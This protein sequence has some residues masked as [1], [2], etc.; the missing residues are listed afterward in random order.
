MKKKDCLFLCQFFSPEYV[1]SATLPFDTAVK[2]AQEGYEIGALCGYPKEY[3]LKTKVANR[4]RVQNV[5]I[6]RLRY[7]QLKRTGFL[8]RGINYASFFFNVLLH[9]P[10]MGGYKLI[11]VYSNPPLLPLAALLAKR[12]FGCQVIFISY[13]V[14]PEIGIC[15][16]KIRRDSMTFRVMELINQDLKKNADYIV[17]LSSDMKEYFVTERK[18]DA[19][20]VKVIPNWYEEKSKEGFCNFRNTLFNEIPKDAFVVSYLGNMGICQELDT[21]LQTARILK[22]D[23]DIYFLF[24]GHGSKL[25]GLIETVKKEQLNQV[26]ILGFLQGKD[27]LDALQISSVC[28]VTLVEGMRGLCSPS[29]VY[30]YMMASKPIIAIID[31]N[32]EL[33]EDI[34]HNRCGYV[35]KHKNAEE[36]GRILTTLKK[37]PG[38]IIQMGNQSRKLFERKYEK[39]I[40]LN[41]Y[42]K[43][44]EKRLKSDVQR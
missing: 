34:I 12:I 33:S 21:I 37:R 14:Y 24:A 15:T 13:D 16:R 28:M 39:E 20:K 29:K 22:E 5:V 35:I 2:L 36:L 4:E 19:T 1:S 17:A 30:G 44:I 8:G 31:E 42:V 3:S 41:K 26:K 9:V 10:Y 7:L 11:F 43:L 32:M 23:K 27:Y 6:K 25:P 38:E 18:V 40:C